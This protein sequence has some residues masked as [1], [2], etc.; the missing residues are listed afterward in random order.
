[1]TYFWFY[2]IVATIEGIL[3]YYVC[4][5]ALN[6]VIDL[7]GHTNGFYD[8]GSAVWYCLVASHHAI[9]L[10]QNRS[11]NYIMI[12]AFVVS[13]LAFP[14]VVWMA[15]SG[16]TETYQTQFTMVFNQPL[17]N[18][19]VFIITFVSIIPRLIWIILEHVVWWP[20][21]AKVKSS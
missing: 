19:T 13:S 16:S 14:L 10:I 15:D 20:Q 1:M 5:Y 21:F 7:E 3:I 9:F 18:F 12:L 2:Y 17:L 4:S 6:N 8:I 11:F